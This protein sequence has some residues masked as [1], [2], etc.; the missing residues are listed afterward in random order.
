[1]RWGE[2]VGERGD[3]GSELSEWLGHGSQSR[4]DMLLLGLER[5][6][7]TSLLLG[8]DFQT[9]RVEKRECVY[10][11]LYTVHTHTPAL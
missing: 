10:V 11:R 3:E 1:M 4:S 8:L 2:G 9:L 5:K 6:Q 7:V